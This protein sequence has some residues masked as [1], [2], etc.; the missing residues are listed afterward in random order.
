LRRQVVRRLGRGFTLIELMIVITIIAVLAAIAIPVYQ[1]YQREALIAKLISHYDD[2]VRVARAEIANRLARLSR[3]ENQLLGLTE[4]YLI[5][6]VLLVDGRGSAPL[7]GPA[8]LPGEPSEET[9]AI[10]VSVRGGTKPGTE[11]VV[12]KRPAFL[13]DVTAESVTIYANSAR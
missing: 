10:G 7:G 11:V 3:G 1:Q 9:G 8:Y 5:E 12:I 6:N 4:M 2:G 13:E